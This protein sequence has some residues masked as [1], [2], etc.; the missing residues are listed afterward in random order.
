MKVRVEIVGRAAA[1]LS[2]NNNFQL[3]VNL[4]WVFLK[5]DM[6]KVWIKTNSNKVSRHF[7]LMIN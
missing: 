7:F 6:N 4:K 5:Y 3:K 2:K 1:K